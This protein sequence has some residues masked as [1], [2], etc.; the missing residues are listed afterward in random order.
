LTKTYIFQGKWADAQ[1]TAEAVISSGQYD[2][3]KN[4][5]DI[6][7]LANE[8]GIES[9]YEFQHVQIATGSWGDQN[10]G[11]VTQIYTRG[12]SFTPNWGWGYVCPT[13]NFKA[14]F[15]TDGTGKIID[16]RYALTV[17]EEGDS[18]YTGTP[19]A[20]VANTVPS[21]THRMGRK[22]LVEYTTDMPGM[23]NGPANWRFMRYA[24]LLLWHAEACCQ[25]NKSTEALTSLNKI[26]DRVGMAKVAVTDQ[27]S[28]LKA[29]YHERR[30]ELGLEGHRFFDIIRT[31]RGAECLGANGYT[32]NK[33][34]LPIPK[35]EIDKCDK[36]VNNP[37][38]N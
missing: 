3:E 19:W 11:C 26:R 6:W 9:I 7:K 18:M 20:Q 28:L 21:P 25:Q 16:P 38:Y 12:R 10:E 15:E 32:E 23:S 4:Y 36:L 8:N 13:D 37:Y 24:D 30:V 14:E 31:G 22:Y 35:S 1:T 17:V 33:K 5:A 29:I 2:L 34:Y 27:P